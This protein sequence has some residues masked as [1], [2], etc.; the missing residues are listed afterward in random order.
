MKQIKIISTDKQP[1]YTKIKSV[2][3]LLFLISMGSTIQ[4]QTIMLINQ[5]EGRAITRNNFNEKGIFLNIQTFKA[6]KLNKNGLLTFQQFTEADGSYFIMN[7][8]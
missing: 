7:Y 5:I 1:V 6:E 3:L 8:N 4:S 2:I